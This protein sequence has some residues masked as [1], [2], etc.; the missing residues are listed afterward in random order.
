VNSPYPKRIV[1]IVLNSFESDNRVLRTAQSLSSAGYDVTVLALKLGNLPAEEV[2]DGF[3]VKRME[4]ISRKLP[5]VPFSTMLQT[6]ETLMRVAKECAKYDI[7]H[8]N[9]FLPMIAVAMMKALNPSLKVVY[10]SHEYARERKGLDAVQKLAVKTLEPLVIKFADQVMTVSDSI[11]A[12]YERLYNLKGVHTILNTP[13][14]HNL[15]QSNILRDNLKIPTSKTIFLYQ[16]GLID[17]RG[18]HLLLRAFE[19]LQD[20]SAVIVFMGYGPFESEVVRASLLNSNVYYQKSVPYDKLVDYTSSA[21]YG[22]LSVENVCLSYYYCMPNKLFEYIQARIPIITTNLPDC[23]GVVETEELGLVIPE[24]T[25]KSF[26][27]T[28]KK[29]LETDP[30]KFSVA[31]EVAAQKYHWQNEEKKLLDIFASLHS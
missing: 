9:D 2:R 15:T 30:G 22:L 3:R 31:L 26:A 25:P 24:F 17:G 8:C 29:A 19:E 23:R 18:I 13:H 6:S 10:D 5:A 21:D 14:R 1:S 16:G 7:V 4:V 12:E 11:A 20:T 27:S 28:I